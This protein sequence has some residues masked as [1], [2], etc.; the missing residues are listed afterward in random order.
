MH[1]SQISW[2]PYSAVRVGEA[3][4][5]GPAGYRRSSRLRIKR[6]EV[7][8]LLSTF[9]CLAQKHGVITLCQTLWPILRQWLDDLLHSE[10]DGNEDTPTNT[11]NPNPS[12]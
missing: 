7:D 12:H 5:P 4:N 8:S 6:L 3:Q 10:Y 11:V 2:C 9:S 1:L